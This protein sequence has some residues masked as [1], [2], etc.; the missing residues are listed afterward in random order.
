MW[1]N[2]VHVGFSEAELPGPSAP[3]EQRELTAH[4]DPTAP[5]PYVSQWFPVEQVPGGPVA[6]AKGLGKVQLQLAFEEYAEAAES[7]DGDAE[8]LAGGGG[9][10]AL[11]LLAVTIIEARGLPSM[12]LFG[13][14]DVFC[15]ATL[16]EMKEHTQTVDGG[17]AAPVWGLQGMGETLRFEQVSGAIDPQSVPE[18]RIDVEDEDKRSN[19]HI[20]HVSLGLDTLMAAADFFMDEWCDLTAESGKKA[21]Q[22][23]VV[24]RWVQDEPVVEPVVEPARSSS[25]DSTGSEGERDTPRSHEAGGVL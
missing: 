13:K 2:Q 23:H 16:G 19:E 4:P 10:A 7:E 15:V 5:L 1:V 3:F 21:G 22:V 6:G 9:G 8:A 12:D 17:G 24:L 14:N 18:L 11:G 20:G 25:S